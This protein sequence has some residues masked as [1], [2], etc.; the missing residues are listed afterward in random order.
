[1]NLEELNL[2]ELNV[3]ESE[4]V[5]GGFGPLFYALAVFALGVYNGYNAAAN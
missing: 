3:Q 4:E 2:V 1:M 5:E